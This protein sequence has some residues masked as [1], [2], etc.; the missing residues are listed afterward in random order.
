MKRLYVIVFL[1][2]AATAA[3]GLAIA[4]HSGYVLIAYKTPL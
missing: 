1:A 3:L 4:E 2:I